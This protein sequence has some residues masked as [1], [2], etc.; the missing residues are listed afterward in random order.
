M[1][2]C[3]MW[4]P[5]RIQRGIDEH[6]GATVMFFVTWLLVTGIPDGPAVVTRKWEESGKAWWDQR[7][8]CLEDVVDYRVYLKIYMPTEYS[9]VL[10]S[11]FILNHLY[12][13]VLHTLSVPRINF[14][15]TK[16]IALKASISDRK[17]VV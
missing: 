10:S 16:Y 9:M 12:G 4:S 11:I 13:I 5:G 8:A 3:G 17:S 14:K 7:A 6:V 1:S 15:S 2:P